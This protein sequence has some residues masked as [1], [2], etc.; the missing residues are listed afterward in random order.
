MTRE[1]FRKIRTGL[2]L[3]QQQLSEKLA[4]TVT[5]VARWE[6]GTR[7]ISEHTARFVRLLGESETKPTKG[8]RP[9]RGR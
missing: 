9:R 6:A 4:V 8:R 2:G 3:T 5:S 1:E 7:P